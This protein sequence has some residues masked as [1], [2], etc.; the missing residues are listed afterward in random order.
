MV[1]G[2]P[3]EPRLTP[4]DAAAEVARRAAGGQPRT[5]VIA[6]VAREHGLRRREVYDAVLAARRRRRPGAHA[7]GPDAHAPEGPDAHA[8]EGP[9]AHAPEG[10]AGTTP[11][12]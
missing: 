6:A 4:A 2:D 3:G 10:P 9:D 12:A 7:R 5:E 11:S 1:E 8:P